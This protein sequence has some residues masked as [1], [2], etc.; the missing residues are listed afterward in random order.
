MRAAFGTALTAA[1]AASFRG[2]APSSYLG[3]INRSNKLGT[4]RAAF[5][6]TTMSGYG[7]RHSGGSGR[8]RSQGRGRGRGRGRGGRGDRSRG[9]GRG[10]GGGYDW[11]RHL[12]ADHPMRRGLG[13]DP[14]RGRGRSRGGRTG[15]GGDY[16]RNNDIS[17]GIA[18]DQQLEWGSET[19]DDIVAAEYAAYYQRR[20]VR[21]REQSEKNRQ[22]FDK[23][24]A[25]AELRRQGSLSMS[26]DIDEDMELGEAAKAAQRAVLAMS[27]EEKEAALARHEERLA[28]S[29]YSK[30]IDL[31]PEALHLSPH[32]RKELD[33]AVADLQ[34]AR[35]SRAEKDEHA[36]TAPKKKVR[37]ES[38]AYSASFVS[39]RG[40]GPEENRE[41]VAQ[42]KSSSAY[43]AMLHQRKKLP[44][45]NMAGAIADTLLDPQTTMAVV[46]GETGCGKTTQIPR[47]LAEAAADRNLGR[48]N[49]LVAQP[50]RIAA[51]G[52]AERVAQEGGTGR[53]PGDEGCDVG[54]HIRHE[55]RVGKDASI[56][57]ATTGIVLRILAGDPEL[58]GV[59]VVI[60]DEVHERSSDGDFS[61]HGIRRSGDRFKKR[62]GHRSPVEA[63]AHV[64]HSRFRFLCQLSQ[65][66][67]QRQ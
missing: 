38:N 16:S 9:G 5:A 52:V 67:R 7:R 66:G 31:Q 25:H 22:E 63:R 32:I 11:T 23:V 29:Q 15:R 35:K 3:G 45:H 47:I 58:K 61:H 26:N 2:G 19:E 43:Q 50:R 65:R 13:P 56:V 51:V 27:E 24:S 21:R 55:R 41:M 34:A 53:V 10:G 54:Y 40:M 39:N 14:S 49:I 33:R 36:D 48:L 44:T 20:D 46:S 28:R 42:R 6:L 62:A 8:G 17:S 60:I 37:S 64:G 30:A 59:D 12:P 4:S 57:F 18:I 1:T